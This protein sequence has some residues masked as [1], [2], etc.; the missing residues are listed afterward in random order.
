MDSETRSAIARDER[1]TATRALYV[2]AALEADRGTALDVVLHALRD[3]A[4]A[5]DLYVDVLQA[6]LYEV[7]RLWEANRITVAHEHAAT[8]ITQLV[9][10]HLYERLE[11]P[12]SL[13]RGRLL[14]T[15]LEGELHSIGALMV[16]DVL[17]SGGWTV[18]FLGTDL[19]HDAVLDAVRRFE[20]DWIG[21]SATMRSNI[22]AARR[23]IEDARRE[24]A[25][26]VQIIVGGAA[27]RHTSDLW[28]ELGADAHAQD[29]R[30]AI[31]VMCP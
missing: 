17:E 22:Q 24:R 29:V 20:P 25:G 15:G 21:I 16:A 8:A 26:A 6:A 28:R 13:P 31:R 5:V 1:L 2:Q 4:S 19:P 11:R 23:L 10:A 30:E 12:T 3:G 9:A 27:F 14:I 18:C 7:G